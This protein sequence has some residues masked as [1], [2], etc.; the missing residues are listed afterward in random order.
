LGNPGQTDRFYSKQL[1]LH[2]SQVNAESRLLSWRGELVR[3]KRSD[4]RF[5]TYPTNGFTL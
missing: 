5:G 1:R 3:R 4:G 2:Q